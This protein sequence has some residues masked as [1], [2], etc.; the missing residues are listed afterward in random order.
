MGEGYSIM[1]DAVL[2]LAADGKLTRIDVLV[3][4][5]LPA[6]ATTRSGETKRGKRLCPKPFPRKKL[7]RRI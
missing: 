6:V 1:P 5:V 2:D 7:R 4:A 3:Y